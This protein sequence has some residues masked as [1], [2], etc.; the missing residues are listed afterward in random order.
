V[1]VTGEET[2]LRHGSGLGIWL[3]R[4]LISV[5]GGEIDVEVTDAGTEVTLWV[6][7]APGRRDSALAAPER[8]P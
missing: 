5:L 3:I 1:L 8:M 4:M 2:P 6:P 7:A